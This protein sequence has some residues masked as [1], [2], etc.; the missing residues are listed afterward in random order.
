MGGRGRRTSLE[1]AIYTTLVILAA[2]LIGTVIW[3]VVLMARRKTQREQLRTGQLRVGTVAQVDVNRYP[4]GMYVNKSN[5]SGFSAHVDLFLPEHGV[6]QRILLHL[7]RTRMPVQGERVL[8]CASPR[9][10]ELVAFG[11]P[12]GWAARAPFRLA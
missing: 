11:G 1:S 8:V 10:V 6:S 5:V 3:M 4:A 12:H 2:L 9:A 7:D